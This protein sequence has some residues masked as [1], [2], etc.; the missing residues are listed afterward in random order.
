MKFLILNEFSELK[1]NYSAM[2]KIFMLLAVLSLS[3]ISCRKENAV[4]DPAPPVSIQK[5]VAN[6]RVI[7]ALDS[8]WILEGSTITF[9]NLSANAD[10]YSWN[11]DNGTNSTDKTPSDISFA[12]CGRT[13]T[14]TLTVKNKAGDSSTYSETFNIQCNGKHP[15]GG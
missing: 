7:N 11:F 9:E 12:P 13:Y 4:T 15:V 2:K 6:F 1:R 5:P 8:G 3:S 14:I 10:S